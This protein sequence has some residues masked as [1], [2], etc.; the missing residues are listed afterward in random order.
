MK[1]RRHYIYKHTCLV[2]GKSYIGRSV[3]P[4][5]RWWQHVD[6]ALDGCDSYF[7][8][9]IR[10]YGPDNFWMKV[11]TSRSTM[12]R[13]ALSSTERTTRP[14]KAWITRRRNLALASSQA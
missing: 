5:R 3:D 11:V 8:N 9:A 10:K 13:A 2:S 6:A 1:S 14:K 7:Y 12:K 4:E